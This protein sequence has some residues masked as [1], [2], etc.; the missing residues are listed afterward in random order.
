MRYFLLRDFEDFGEELFRRLCVNPS[1]SLIIVIVDVST[2]VLFSSFLVVRVSRIRVFFYP[3]FKTRKFLLFF[4]P[5][6]E[7]RMRGGE[8][9]REERTCSRAKFFFV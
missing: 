4:F 8:R 1:I 7:G 6:K 2:I 5:R 3:R 9:E